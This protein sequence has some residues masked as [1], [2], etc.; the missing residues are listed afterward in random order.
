ML[1]FRCEHRARF[2]QAELMKEDYVPRPRFECGDVKQSKHSCYMFQP[3]KPCIIAR[4]KL[5]KK[6]FKG[7]R[8]IFGPSMISSRSHFVRIPKLTA[9]IIE[10]E[11]G[12]ILYWSPDKDK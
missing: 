5:E 6:I 3:V 9:K 10:Y 11:D 1:C 4:N 8:P 7:V 12:T 2:L